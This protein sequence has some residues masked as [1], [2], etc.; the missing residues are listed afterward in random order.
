[1][2]GQSQSY[3]FNDFNNS[4]L[5]GL[6]THRGGILGDLPSVGKE[7]HKMHPPN[8]F[9]HNDSGMGGIQS[10]HRMTGLGGT[11]NG[12]N[13]SPDPQGTTTNRHFNHPMML[14]DSATPMFTSEFT[15]MPAPS[16]MVG[17][18]DTALG[19]PH[20]IHEWNPLNDTG[21]LHPQTP[22]LQQVG[23]NTSSDHLLRHESSFY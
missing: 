14:I 5:D 20:L 3:H 13:N 8:F 17:G 18:I 1:M 21:I 4:G 23:S 12:Q 15:I 19:A 9:H 10:T 11:G 6:G 2:L 22:H 7:M 16:M